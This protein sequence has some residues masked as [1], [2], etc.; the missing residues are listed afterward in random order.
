[1]ASRRLISFAVFFADTCSSAMQM[2]R[3][4]NMFRQD[5]SDQEFKFLH[6]FSRIE[7][8]EKWRECLIAMAK[9]KETYKPD[10]PA[11]TAAEGHLDGNKRAKAARDTSPAA[12]RLQSSIEQCI[13][14][15]KNNTA[16]REEKSDARWPALMTKQDVKLDFL[17]TNVA[18]KKRNTNLAF[19]TAADMSTMDEQ[20]K[21]WYLAER[22]LILNQMPGP[23]ATAASTPTPSPST[24]ATPMMSPSTEAA[25]MPSPSTEA[26]PTP[27][28]TPT[29][30]SPTAKEPAV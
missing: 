23:A 9:A 1:M 11:P 8:C 10:T 27:T 16:K 14:D 21:A 3:M 26:A 30:A 4:F 20:V 29:P 15:A 6:V 18:A 28:P 12:E 24:E 22:G 5:N 7:S 19:L 17:R 13:T 25:P 2:V